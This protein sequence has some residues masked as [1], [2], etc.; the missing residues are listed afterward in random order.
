MK[1]SYKDLSKVFFNSVEEMTECTHDFH[2][3]KVN[4]WFRWQY[5]DTNETY[6]GK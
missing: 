4:K 2:K 1:Q 6:R 3:M 5:K